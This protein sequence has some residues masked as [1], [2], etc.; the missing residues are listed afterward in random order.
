VTSQVIHTG[1]TLSVHVP[2]VGDPTLCGVVRPRVAMTQDALSRSNNAPL[3]HAY[4]HPLIMQPLFLIATFES[5]GG[6]TTTY[7]SRIVSSNI[8]SLHGKSFVP[9][10]G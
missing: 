10:T 5:R 2:R 7:H 4:P 6:R 8:T 9:K 3:F 1:F